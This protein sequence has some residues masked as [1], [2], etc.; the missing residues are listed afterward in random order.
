MRFNSFNML[1]LLVS[2]HVGVLAG[3]GLVSKAKEEGVA[4]TYPLT[5]VIPASSST[6]LA[7]NDESAVVTAY[8]VDPTNSENLVAETPV[9]VPVVYD[10]DVPT[11]SIPDASID[12][13]YTMEIGG[14][15]VT[16]AA[17][18]SA[19]GEIPANSTGTDSLEVLAEDNP[20][21]VQAFK[22]HPR[23]GL[24]EVVRSLVGSLN[25]ATYNKDAMKDC[26]EAAAKEIRS[27]PKADRDALKK[28]IR[29]SDGAPNY[30]AILKD[31]EKKD[32]ALTQRKVDEANRITAFYEKRPELAT[33]DAAKLMQGNSSEVPAFAAKLPPNAAGA[34]S[35]EEFNRKVMSVLIPVGSKP[36]KAKLD[37]VRGTLD[38]LAAV[39]VT[40]KE[41][42]PAAMDAVTLAIKASMAGENPTAASIK[43]AVVAAVSATPS[44]NAG[45]LETNSNRF[46][47]QSSGAKKP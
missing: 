43:A 15:D 37:A 29:G 34:A 25:G 22:D 24:M 11:V 39:L 4:T 42:G 5:F 41:T 40:A 46:S 1:F 6:T 16:A 10:G 3:C 45:T 2:G 7:L 9:T 18:N 32:N 21:S 31:P 8:T 30:V 13:S 35:A 44:I 28:E 36:D 19:P 26:L 33:S 14:T 23:D 17:M 27:M 12:K 20:L 38:Y 47:Q